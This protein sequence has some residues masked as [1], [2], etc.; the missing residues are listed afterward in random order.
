MIHCQ[1]R[2]NAPQKLDGRQLRANI[3]NSG[4]RATVCKKNDRY[5]RGQIVYNYFFVPELV[6][7]YGLYRFFIFK[8]F[9]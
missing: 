8:I 2:L 6:Q 3:I 4:F 5:G 7:K 1:S 9:V